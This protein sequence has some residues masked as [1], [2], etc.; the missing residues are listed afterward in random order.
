MSSRRRLTAVSLTCAATVI[1]AVTT[2]TARAR[3]QQPDAAAPALRP[4]N[5]LLQRIDKAVLGGG[6]EMEGY[7]VWCPS[8]VKGDD[9]LYHM[10]ASRWP[11]RL[12]FHPGWMV[13][14][15]VVHATSKTV[16]GPYKF[17]EV[18][19]PARGPQYW[20][21]RSTH[22]PKIVRWKD[23]W[24]LFY[25]GSTHPFDDPRPEQLAL[26]GP[27]TTLARANKRV[28]IATAKSPF[29]PWTR[30]DRPALDTR[31]GTFYS[32]L[33]S[34]P[35]PYIERDGSVLMVFKSRAYKDKYPY[36]TPMFLGVAR[37]PHFDKPFTVVSAQPIFG[38]GHGGEVEDPFIWKDKQG[39]HMIAKDQRGDITGERHGGFIAHSPDGERWKVDAAPR[40]YSKRLTWTD[41][42][43]QVMGQLERASIL[44]ENGVMTHMFFAAMDGSGGFQNGTRTWAQVVRLKPAPTTAA[45]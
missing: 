8:V 45:R 16:E 41:G 2:V 37:A 4:D 20:D 11:K 13:A 17:S 28:G 7:W 31:P 19:L 24:V 27:Y 34:N 26:D 6:F 32:F 35:A 22:N 38:V 1:A 43:V 15:E 10:F 12:P 9:G 29:G 39:F 36:Q 21:G 18:A 42:R 23:T 5:A 30:R 3:A 33:T 40:A 14:S 44:I 25:M